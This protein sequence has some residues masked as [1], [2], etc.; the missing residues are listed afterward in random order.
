MNFLIFFSSVNSA[1]VGPVPR[2]EILVRNS[3]TIIDLDTAQSVPVDGAAKE[4]NHRSY[5]SDPS[6]TDPSATDR[7]NILCIGI[8]AAKC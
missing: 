2:V 8:G 6:A 1:H 3:M 4:L 7:D 5:P